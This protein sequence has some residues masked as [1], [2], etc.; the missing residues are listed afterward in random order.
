MFSL[1]IQIIYP[2]VPAIQHHKQ[3]SWKSTALAPHLFQVTLLYQQQL[4][5]LHHPAF[6][7]RTPH[8]YR[9]FP[10]RLEEKKET[11]LSPFLDTPGRN[12]FIALPG[13]GIL[14]NSYAHQVGTGILPNF[15]AHPVG[16]SLLP[17]LGAP[18]NGRILCNIHPRHTRQEPVFYIIQH[19]RGRRAPPLSPSQPQGSAQKLSS[20]SLTHNNLIF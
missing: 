2:A 3:Q 14:P 12:L 4:S 17:F 6:Q 18:G 13:T 8:L 11:G 19:F 7:P 20:P 15:Y 9:Q 16:T 10:C 1:W 5:C